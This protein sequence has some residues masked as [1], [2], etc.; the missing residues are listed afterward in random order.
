MGAGV[1]YKGKALIEGEYLEAAD[2]GGKKVAR[3]IERIRTGVQLK[4]KNGVDIRPVF[5]L[6]GEKKEWVLNTTNLK[7]IAKVYGFE[8]ESWIGQPVVLVA[9]E[10]DAFGEMRMAI[11]VDVAA[12][13]KYLQL[14]KSKQV[15]SVTDEPEQ[16][17]PPD[18]A[19]PDVNDND[20]EQALANAAREAEQSEPGSLG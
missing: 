7:A 12:T 3:V 8:A 4:K 9:M 17:A 11:R 14:Q 19:P 20:D 5:K 6:R 10:V 16:D 1:T 2:L 15:G 18:D 13:R